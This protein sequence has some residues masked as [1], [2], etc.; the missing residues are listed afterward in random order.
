M[1]RILSVVLLAVL[2]VP[3]FSGVQAAEA[4]IDD[5]EGFGCVTS[6][7]RTLKPKFG[8]ITG[9][10]FVDLPAQR[11]E[12]LDTVDRKIAWCRENTVFTTNTLN[13]EHA[14]C[15]PRF[16][17]QARECIA[18]FEDERHKCE[19]AGDGESASGAGQAADA[20]WP[21]CADLTG[22]YSH[23]EG[24]NHAY[25]QCWLELDNRPGCY[26]YSDHY[27]TGDSIRGLGACRGGVLDG[28]TVTMS[29]GWGSSMGNVV[30]GK[31]SGRQVLRFADGLVME[32]LYVD[33]KSHGHWVVRFAD[34]SVHEGRVVDDERTGYWVERNA[35]GDVWEG[36]YVDGKPHGRWVLQGPYGECFVYEYRHGEQGDS[37]RC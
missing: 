28:G 9:A 12:C 27:H 21:K 31:L 22:S 30:D 16:E 37:V 25:A 4:R 5:F 2:M 24:D 7:G 20:L 15:L 17:E 10:Y 36:P 3:G 19:G 18:F 29:G 8:D 11:Q 33:G 34:G 6:G 1:K 13:Q 26:F 23:V 35:D 14:A 32:G